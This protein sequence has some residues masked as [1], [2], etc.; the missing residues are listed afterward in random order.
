[1][2]APVMATDLRASAGLI[3][4]A[5]GWQRATL[6]VSR[7]YHIDRGYENG[8]RQSSAAW[9]PRSAGRA[10]RQMASQND[11]RRGPYRSMRCRPM[12]RASMPS[13][14]KLVST[15]RRRWRRGRGE[16]GQEDRRTRPRTVASEELLA[17]IK[18]FDGNEPRRALEVQ[19]RK[20]FEEA[21][22]RS[23]D[24]AN[25]AALGKAAMRVREFHRKR[26][27]SSWEVRE[28][29]GGTFGHR[30]RPMRPRQASTCPAARRSI[31]PPSS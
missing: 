24:P 7:V 4:A 29:G 22:P 19:P 31:R 26:I 9:E 8:S 16:D 28:E 10:E 5:S 13:F 21:L 18:K 20:E 3:V 27:P 11:C 30:V 17:C 1:M 6:V 25:R 14:E 23:I 2:G 12:A 15:P